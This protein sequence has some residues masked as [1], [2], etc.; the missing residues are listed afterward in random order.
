M[1]RPPIY[2][3]LALA[4]C[5]PSDPIDTASGSVADTGSTSAEGS[6]TAPT[7]GSSTGTTEAGSTT[8]APTGTS[9]TTAESLC[10]NGVIDFGEPCDDGNRV[11]ADGCNRDC[12]LSG[13]LLWEFRS[14]IFVIDD[15]N[16]VAVGPD[17]GIVAAGYWHGE[18]RWLARFD[19]FGQGVWSRTFKT[20]KFEAIHGVVV[21]EAAIY[22]AGSVFPD[23]DR[24]VWVGRHALD[25][26]LE[27][28]AFHDSGFGDD[29]ATAI[30]RTPEGDLVVAGLASLDGGLAE[31]WT[32]RYGPDGAVQWTQGHPINRGTLY[33]V[34]PGVVAAQEQIVVGYG[35]TLQPDVF[36]ELL[37]AYPPD[38]AAPLWTR[39]I[40]TAPGPIRGLTRDAGG[41]LVAATSGVMVRRLTSA[42]KPLWDGS[43]CAASGRGI[44]VDSQ[45]DVVVAGYAGGDIRICKLAGDGA[46]RWD[47]TIDG[48]EGDDYGWSVAL[49][50]D[51]RIVVAGQIENG[52]VPDAWLAMFTP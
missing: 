30:A 51:D 50:P 14:G 28:E 47:R 27:W 9:A 45:G 4:G 36:E 40:P 33:S 20:A 3:L 49:F 52:Q 24:N 25:G 15:F 44:A 26:T 34:G 10:G 35:H 17:G 12:A 5:P 13:E 43:A 23:A 19:E 18:G 29:Y 39:S 2:I 42:G 31:L 1:T 37:V 21:D 48:G 11:N 6:T 32:R 38:G 22:A 7:T 41:D 16:A 8:D 46:L